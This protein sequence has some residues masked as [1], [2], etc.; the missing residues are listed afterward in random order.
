M[1]AK[2]IQKSHWK[3][4]PAIK[5]H[6]VS[7]Q[8]LFLSTGLKADTAIKEVLYH[9]TRGVGKT[10]ALLVSFA[11]MVGKG[12]GRKCRGIIFRKEYKA[13][14]DVIKK[15]K[16]LFNKLFEEGTCSF[17]ES[18]SDYK[19]VWSSGEELL[20][21]AIDNVSDYDDKY[22]GQE[23]TFIG[24]EELCS[25][26]DLSLY[27]TMMSCLRTSSDTEDQSDIPPLLV[28]ATT[29]PYGAGRSAVKRYFI[30]VSKSGE[31]YKE[32]IEDED[33]VITTKR[34]HIFGSFR[35]NI[36]LGKGYAAS[37]IQ[38][39]ETDYN[40][41][42]SWM[43]G[44]WEAVS[45]GM[46]G[47]L[48]KYDTNVI[49]PFKVPESFYIDRSFDYG[50][51]SP[52]SCLWFAEATGED[53]YDA[54]GNV[55]S[56]PK[57]SLILINEYYGAASLSSNNTGL[58]LNASKIADN[59]KVKENL[60][61]NKVISMFSNINAGP[62]DN[63]I[64]N[65]SKVR[66]V[67]TVADLFSDKGISWT[68]SNK[69]KGT[70]VAGVEYFKEMLIATK[71]KD[72]SMPHFYIFDTCKFFINNVPALQIDSKNPDDVDTTQPDHDWDALRYRLLNKKNRFKMF[73]SY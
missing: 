17:K 56:I 39:K 55:M 28:R 70:R 44:D 16:I 35:E 1:S 58:N 14:D 34:M 2:T 15:S 40:K 71:N 9:G 36:Y 57:G 73:N 62:A 19:W 21:R 47:D 5:G 46:F 31:V 3:P 66:G 30:D 11:I 63:S 53:F 59:I 10:E 43:Y 68:K 42:R 65:D 38:L 32:D 6:K 37:F 27:H 41:Y 24:W 64:W 20:F 7:S 12:Y 50:T 45:G 23:F 22:H 4:F 54:N 69:S 61:K 49:K 33:G 13:L 67:K 18:K 48:Y 8:Q 25:W 72:N 60:M 26:P 52:F 51:A 29:N